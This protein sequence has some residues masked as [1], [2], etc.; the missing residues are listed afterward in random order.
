MGAYGLIT[1]AAIA[2]LSVAT[3]GFLVV[4]VVGAVTPAAGLALPLGLVLGPVAGVGV[5]AGLVIA[6]TI[7]SS[8][9]WWTALDAIAYGGLAYLGY[10]LWGVLPGV[11][12]GDPPLLRAAGQWIEF[13]VVT[14]LGCVIATL[15]L[16]WGTIVFW[17]TPFHAVVLPELVSLLVSTAILGPLLIV[18]ATTVFENHLPQY[19][20]RQAIAVR[21][22]A[23]WGGVAAPLLWL[24]AATA[25]SLAA[26]DQRIQVVG[27]AIV[28]SLVIATVRPRRERIDGKPPANTTT[29]A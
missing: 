13:L 10:R 28:L 5:A 3:G 12:T 6:G 17:G 27:G 15:A 16:A 19:R 22:G 23:F 25:L 21:E 8:L 29:D 14:I 20:H 2:L 26:A 18:P 1:T 4:P 7:Q 9:S 11:A 24:F